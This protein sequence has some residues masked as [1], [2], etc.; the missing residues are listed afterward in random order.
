MDWIVPECHNLNR[1]L[2]LKTI[3]CIVALLYVF[4]PVMHIMLYEMDM[5]CERCCDRVASKKGENRF[6]VQEYFQTIFL[7]LVNEQFAISI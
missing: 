1:D 7:S 6:T 3:G 5:L 2:Y 4:N